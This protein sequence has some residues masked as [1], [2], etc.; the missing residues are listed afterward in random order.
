MPRGLPHVVSNA[1]NNVTN[2]HFTWR[3]PR[4]HSC[5]R[6]HYG[7]TFDVGLFNPHDGGPSF[8]F[9]C[10]ASFRVEGMQRMRQLSL[11]I[12]TSAKTTNEHQYV[13]PNHKISLGLSLSRPY[14]ENISV[15]L[16]YTQPQEEVFLNRFGSKII[17]VPSS[18]LF[19][20]I[21]NIVYID[22]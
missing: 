12:P 1:R 2:G 7:L 5:R 18:Q 6:G 22:F 4:G 16:Y 13:L 14:T 3:L 9:H 19:F 8:I 10:R 11:V 17:D 21:L 20:A 15:L